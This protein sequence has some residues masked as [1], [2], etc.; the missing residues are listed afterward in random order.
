MLN[1]LA[2]TKEIAP[3]RCRSTVGVVALGLLGAIVFAL[4]H[5]QAPLF[6]LNQNQY[7]LHGLAAAGHGFL[8]EDWLANTADPTPVFSE[9]VRLTWSYVGATTFY[10]YYGSLLG[11]Y[12]LSLIAIAR[13]VIPALRDATLCLCF[14]TILLVVHAAAVRLL[15]SAL[16]G[17]DYLW[18]LQAGLA[19]QYTLGGFFQ[20]SMFGTLLLLSIAAFL[21]QRPLLAVSIAAV[22]ADVHATYLLG[23]AALTLAYGYVLMRERQ[24]KKALAVGGIALLVVLPV[25]IYNVQQFRPT[26]SE[27]FQEAQR[28]L[29]RFRI[30]H[31]CMLRQWFSRFS[32]GQLCWVGVATVLVRRTR[33]CAIFAISLLVMALLTLVQQLTD[34]DSIALLFPWRISIYLVPL[35]TAVILGQATVLVGDWVTR[36]RRSAI[37]G[38]IIVAVVVCLTSLVAGADHQGYELSAAEGPMMRYVQE[39]AATGQ[40]YLVPVEVPKSLSTNESHLSVAFTAIRHRGRW[41]ADMQ[42]FRLRTGVPIF[43]EFKAIPYK[44]VEVLEWRRR[45]ERTRQAF[46]AIQHGQ[47]AELAT[48]CAAEGITHVVTVAD[49]EI[50]GASFEL[51]Y[52]DQYYRV[53]RLLQTPGTATPPI[54]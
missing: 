27:A 25:L 38:S 36:H 52:H 20:P 1:G 43:V 5:T 48:L 19:G 47:S 35:A 40:V 6:Y 53:Y 3:P 34:S 41:L 17:R 50:H 28:I 12:Y 9:L 24:F 8:R 46:E 21:Y 45:I 42:T 33:L 44:D 54:R 29:A 16:L 32:A 26:T 51:Q 30:P 7:F 11:T 2:P 15:S 31:H 18:Y 39:H 37:A 13:R 4:T 23:A 49:E 14:A 22:A 10:V